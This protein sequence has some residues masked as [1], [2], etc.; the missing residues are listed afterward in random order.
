MLTLDTSA[1]YALVNRRDPDHEAVREALLADGGPWLVPA[2]ILGEIAHLIEARLGGRVLDLFLKDLEEGVFALDCG[3]ERIGRARA[4]AARYADLPLGFADAA[5]AAC[6]AENGGRV[7]TL[8]RRGF[9]VL[10]GELP[11]SLLP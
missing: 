7:L 5:V 2:A 9:E 3:R 11:L 4:L 10:A 8:D 1:L 6:A